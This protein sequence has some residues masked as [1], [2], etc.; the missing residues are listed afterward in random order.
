MIVRRPSRAYRLGEPLP[1]LGWNTVPWPWKPS[2]ALTEFST[3]AL[4][5]PLGTVIETV[6][7]GHPAVAQIQTH[8]RYGARPDLSPRPH[9]GTSVF[10]LASHNDDGKL[11]AVIDPPEGWGV[12][13]SGSSGDGISGEVVPEKPA[14]PRRWAPW[15]PPGVSWRALTKTRKGHPWLLAG[16]GLA[17]GAVTIGGP[18]AVTVG[19]LAG[20]GANRLIWR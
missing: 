7:D 12:A 11:C 3:K 19:L 5:L 16:A 14:T 9:A 4:S 6:L 8:D 1:P 17:L 18:L 20:L 13:D 10:A 2:A 15:V